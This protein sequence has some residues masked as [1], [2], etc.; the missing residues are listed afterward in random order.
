MLWNNRIK[1]RI[2]IARKWNKKI[3][4]AIAK[5]MEKKKWWVCNND[6]IIY[7]IFI[8]YIFVLLFVITLQFYILL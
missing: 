3:T 2:K 5:I 1:I 7:S 4:I 8:V 6:K